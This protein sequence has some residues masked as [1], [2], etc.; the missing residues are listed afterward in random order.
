ML[1]RELQRKILLT[2]SEH[3][4]AGILEEIEELGQDRKHVLVQL[5]YLA[6]HGLLENGYGKSDFIGAETEFFCKQESVITA[7]GLDF[8]EDDGGLSAVLGVQTIKIHDDTIKDL[9][10]AKIQASDLLPQDKQRFIAK[11]KELPAETTKHLVLKLVDLGIDK[12]P[13]AISVLGTWLK[14]L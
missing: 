5:F 7:K 6:E 10:E 14:S 9:I 11:L 3:Y 8:L 2:L 13:G 12:A 1:D 4:P